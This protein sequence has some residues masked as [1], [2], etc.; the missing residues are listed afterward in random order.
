MRVLHVSDA[1]L[2]RLGGIEMQVDDIV[3]RLRTAGHDVHVLTV[4]DNPDATQAGAEPGLT[5][6]PAWSHSSSSRRQ[7]DTLVGWADVVHVHVSLISPLAWFATTRARLAGVPVVATMHSVIG[8]TRPVISGMLRGLGELRWTAVSQVA[9]EPL[10]AIVRRPVHV[11]P[12]GVEPRRWQPR[13]EEAPGPLTLIAVNRLARRK[14]VL[15]LLR[16]LAEVRRQVPDDVALRALIVG[17]GPQLAAAT[18]L[19]KRLGLSSWVELTGRL[20][21]AAVDDQLAAAHVFLAPARLE[22]FGI[23]AL[24]ARCAGLPVVAMTAGGVG[25]FVSDG[26]EGLLV[27]DDAAM[28]RAISRL[29]TDTLLRRRIRTHNATTT[30]TLDWPHTLDATLAQYE[31]VLA[32]KWPNERGSVRAA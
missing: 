6:V 11:L 20:D 4:T 10:A 19:R 13:V 1:Y 30:T 22:S 3:R 23:A 18:R 9:A 17:D 12:N 26:R 27:E 32:T 7:V 24:E 15:P 14:R 29:A 31:A 5:R 25:E 2:P 8:W 21:R 28:A 16:G